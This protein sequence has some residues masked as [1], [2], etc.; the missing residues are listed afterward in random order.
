MELLIFGTS[1]MWGQGLRDADKMH[2][3][4]ARKLHAHQPD[5]RVNVTFLAHSGASTGY[6]PDGT[7]DSKS[8]PL[9][10]GEVPT[11]YPTILQEIDSFDQVGIAPESI[12]LI[13]LD[14]GINDVHLKSV[15]DP[16]VTPRKI[17]EMVELYCHQHM[18]LLLSKLLDKFPRARIVVAGYYEFVTEDSEQSYVRGL[19]QTFGKVPG[20]FVFDGMLWLLNRPIRQRLLT[21]C[22]TFSDRSWAA[23]NQTADEMNVRTPGNNR[24]L[25]ARP[26]IK[27]ENAAFASDPWLFGLTEDASP[28][29]PMAQERARACRAAGSRAEPIFCSTA[30]TGHPN[31]KGT[32]AYAEAILAVL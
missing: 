15:L 29:D 20:G 3:V 25:V 18:A 24:V 6:L 23:F 12:D 11:R 5:R 21:N 14:A 2:N 16:L 19:L 8:A 22:D 32:N 17:A 9:I 13:V 27:P 10:N 31:P 7:I 26:N 1:L 4:L 30:S 28:E